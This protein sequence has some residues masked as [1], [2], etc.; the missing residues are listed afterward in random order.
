MYIIRQKKNK[1]KLKDESQLND[2]NGFLFGSKNK[3]YKIAGEE[4]TSLTI[5]NKKL[6]SPIAKKQVDHKYGRLI[7]LLTDLLVSD[8]DSGECYK[9]A[10]NQIERFRQIIK[11]KY[12]DY[13]PKKELEVMGKNLS[14]FQKEAKNRFMELQNTLSKSSRKSSCK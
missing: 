10:L 7:S 2:M 4:V 13:L 1:Y 11:N 9:E 12:R 3:G 14:M 5:Y 6:A 8:D